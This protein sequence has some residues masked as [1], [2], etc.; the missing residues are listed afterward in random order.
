[1]LKTPAKT[2]APK[3]S[4]GKFQGF[5][6]SASIIRWNPA[7]SHQFCVKKACGMGHSP[8][9]CRM[10]TA[11]CRMP[12]AS[13]RNKNA[14]PSFQRNGVASPRREVNS[15]TVS[16]VLPNRCG[17]ETARTPETFGKTYGCW[18]GAGVFWAEVGLLSTMFVIKRTSTRRFSARPLP[19]LFS[20]TGLS[21]P[22]PIT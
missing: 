12:H 15:R 10:L 3:N 4:P 5:R 1:M 20:A 9:N 17:P 6:I 14:V 21:L 13:C 2:I 8:A 7:A 22:N 19:F 16:G 18:T 11:A